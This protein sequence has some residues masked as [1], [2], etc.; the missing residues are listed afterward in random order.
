VAI[1]RAEL[2]RIGDDPILESWVLGAEG[3]I[4]YLGDDHNGA[5]S[6]ARRSLLLKR[7]KLGPEH[8]DVLN[9][10]M[11]IGEILANAHHPDEALD[12]STEAREGFSRVLGPQHAWV[13]MAS[14]NE[15]EAL[16]SLR[17]YGDAVV[18][19]ERALEI[20]RRAGSDPSF[21]SYGLVG[22]GRARLGLGQ[23]SQAVPLLEE[24]NR[25]RG[26]KTFG[27]QQ[28]GEVR[29][30]LAEALWLRRQPGDRQR[31]LSLARDA[32][33]NYAATPS[34]STLLPEVDGWLKTA[35]L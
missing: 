25:I 29:F 19:F 34:T 31:A 7:E 35:R 30:A 32:R 6:A 33:T 26:E 8:P 10:I 24:A 12:A 9:T 17:R 22:L 20:W 15:G 16:N 27:R 3:A 1:A 11:S 23:A 18:A 14:N 5:L 21:A 2:G 28:V 13:A 4:L